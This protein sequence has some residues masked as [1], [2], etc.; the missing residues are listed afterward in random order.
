MKLSKK[1]KKAIENNIGLIHHVINKYYPNFYATEYDDLV[2]IGS[3][4]LIKAIKKY[5]SKKSKL[6]TYATYYI[7]SEIDHHF[8]HLNTY[9]NKII[10]EAYTLE[11][12]YHPL[13]IDKNYN[14]TEI[15]SILNNILNNSNLSDMEKRVILYSYYGFKN[16]QIAK[17]YNKTNVQIAVMIHQARKKIKQLISKNP[18]IL[19]G[20]V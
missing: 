20:V 2:Q 10:N 18:N 17:K 13:F 12:Y 5:N 8:N 16:N 11:E 19:E 9:K 3:I 6:S 7:R 4:G 14:E 1:N 15:N